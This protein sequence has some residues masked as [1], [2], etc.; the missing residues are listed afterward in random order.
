[1][2][3][4]QFQNS[5]ALSQLLTKG[6]VATLR[7]YPYK[8]KQLVI[9]NKKFKA[10]ITKVINEYTMTDVENYA[11]ISGFSD[12]AEWIDA[13]C[14]LNEGQLPKYLVVVEMLY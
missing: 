7:N 2:I 8:E 11:V 14:E 13:A 4:M 5:K 1:M 6:M 10:K 9:I 3:S 12:N